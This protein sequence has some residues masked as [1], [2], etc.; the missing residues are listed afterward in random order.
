MAKG[1]PINV[2]MRS[3]DAKTLISLRLPIR[4][5]NQL[6]QKAY[7]ERVSMNQLLLDAIEGVYPPDGEDRRD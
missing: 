3:E 6:A 2:E 1:P 4:Y 7:D 5:R